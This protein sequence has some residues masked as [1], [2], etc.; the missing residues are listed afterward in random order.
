MAKQYRLEIL[1]L[2]FHGCNRD[3]KPK[4]PTQQRLAGRPRGRVTS[5]VRAVRPCK[6][7]K[8]ETSYNLGR[9]TGEQNI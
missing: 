3:R 4:D 9:A 2:C 7:E 8:D 1:S 6:G 5:T